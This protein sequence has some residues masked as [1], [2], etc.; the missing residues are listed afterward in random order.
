MADVQGTATSII[1]YARYGIDKFREILMWIAGF[2]AEWID[3]PVN[4]IY[5]FLL[6]L[7]AL[8]VAKKIIF[9]R[10]VTV[11]GRWLQLLLIAAVVFFII[12]VI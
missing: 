11:K 12:K 1:G 4:N 8:W 10:Y 5:N 7:V 2:I 9:W 3:F 6:I